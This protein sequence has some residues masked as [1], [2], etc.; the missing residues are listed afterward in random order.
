MKYTQHK[1]TH[2]MK[3][4][5]FGALFSFPSSCVSIWFFFSYLL[6]SF[7][8]E[9]YVW[10]NFHLLRV[11]GSCDR[12][13][14][15]TLDCVFYFQFFSASFSLDFYCVKWFFI[16]FLFVWR[17]KEFRKYRMK[18]FFKDIQLIFKDS[19][20]EVQVNWC[21]APFN[22]LYVAKTANF[23]SNKFRTFWVIENTRVKEITNFN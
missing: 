2:K 14:Y 15:T 13:A 4:Y 16:G 23:S 3:L 12:L 1:L 17:I 22:Q 20:N 18:V 7:D 21:F 10:L 11:S 19:M 9:R 8:I 5:F 6:P